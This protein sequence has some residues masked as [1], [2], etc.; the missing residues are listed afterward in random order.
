MSIRK[1]EKDDFTGYI[2]L[3]SKF[4]SINPQLD[5]ITFESIYDIIFKSGEIYVYIIN[6]III[7]SI[8]VL[9]EQKYIHDCAIYAHIEDIFV[10][11]EYRNK[12]IGSTLINHI[13]TIAKEK[14]CFKCTLVCSEN[15]KNFY[16]NNDF[17][18]RGLNMS[19]LL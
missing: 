16:V 13:K 19:F 1:L 3:I 9:Y 10:Y 2:K 15:N 17:E 14:K 11:E 12:R 18:E 8:K 5:K 7:G 4:R 6:N